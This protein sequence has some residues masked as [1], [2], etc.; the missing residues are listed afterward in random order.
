[1]PTPVRSA[2]DLAAGDY[3]E[4]CAFHPCI[5]IRV[6]GDDGD[7]VNGISLVDGSW[8]R[9]CSIGLC[10]VRKLTLAEALQWRFFGPPDQTVPRDKRWW[11]NGP[12]QTWLESFRGELKGRAAA[13]SFAIEVYFAPPG[14]LVRED[15]LT[16]VVTAAG[17]IL[18]CREDATEHTGICL[19]FEFTSYEQAGNCAATLR[20]QGE[21]IEGPFAYG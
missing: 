20:A 12:K 18:S 14:E 4:D 19:T 8:P 21:H 10:G 11:Q 2:A 16:D 15:R 17:G 5:C 6:H 1:M 9:A 3:Y 7:E 13:E